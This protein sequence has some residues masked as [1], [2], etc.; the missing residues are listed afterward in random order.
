LDENGEIRRRCGKEQQGKFVLILAYLILMNWKLVVVDSQH[1]LNEG[2]R[3]YILQWTKVILVG[4]ISSTS[5]PCFQTSTLGQAGVLN[6]SSIG[7]QGNTRAYFGRQLEQGEVEKTLRSIEKFVLHIGTHT[8][9]P[10]EREYV[11]L[12]AK[13]ASETLDRVLDITAV[14]G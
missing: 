8:A 13:Q 14:V 11:V 4:P 9:L 5:S 7:W 1:A 10:D 3:R 2:T 6:T 12:T